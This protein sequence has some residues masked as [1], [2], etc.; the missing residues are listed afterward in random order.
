[1]FKVRPF[2]SVSLDSQSLVAIF[3]N[4]PTSRLQEVGEIL[5]L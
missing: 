3:F 2:L 5:A 4:M 1:M